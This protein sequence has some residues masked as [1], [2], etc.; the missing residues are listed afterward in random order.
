MSIIR[1]NGLFVFC[2][3]V[4]RVP[5]NVPREGP[6]GC[7]P[8]P[9]VHVD[10]QGSAKT[11][12]GASASGFLA[13]FQGGVLL[14]S[15]DWPEVTLC[16]WQ[17]VRIQLLNNLLVRIWNKYAENCSVVFILS[18]FFVCVCVYASVIAALIVV[19]RD[20]VLKKST[21]I[22][23]LCIIFQKEQV[24]LKLV[25]QSWVCPTC[26]L[27]YLSSFRRLKWK[28]DNLCVWYFCSF[29]VTLL[30]DALPLLETPQV[31]SLE[32]FWKVQQQILHMPNSN[33]CGSGCL[34]S[35][36]ELVHS[37]QMNQPWF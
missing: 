32:G 3:Q 26:Y 35:S 30:M 11:V 13:D 33:I 20:T 10:G 21:I 8:P 7:C 22:I 23:L 17:D 6:Q 14:P 1:H 31:S 19:R 9:A 2:R 16:G 37:N 18:F 27:F 29:W 4:P 34:L 15:R 25:L 36:L 28:C 12:S 5:Q 24:Y